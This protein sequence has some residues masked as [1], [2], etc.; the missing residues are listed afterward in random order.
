MCSRCCAMRT[1]AMVWR[2]SPP[3][4]RAYDGWY[5]PVVAAGI[6]QKQFGAASSV[7]CTSVRMPA[8][9][10][11]CMYVSSCVFMCVCCCLVFVLPEV[12]AA[13]RRMDGVGDAVASLGCGDVAKSGGGWRAVGEVLHGVAEGARSARGRWGGGAEGVQYV[14]GYLLKM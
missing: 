2:M 10:M 1:T 12:A 3:L 8:C 5:L 11:S 13:G 14:F 9:W 6:T 7:N 4:P